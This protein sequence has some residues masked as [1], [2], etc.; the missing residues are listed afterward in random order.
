M[1]AIVHVNLKP[2]VL[3]PQGRAIARS[4]NHMGFDMVE[5][6]RQGK[7]LELDLK[8]DNPE[9][10]KAEVEKMCEQLLAN[11]VIENYEFEISE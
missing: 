3:D 6:V 10:A 7:T 11:T 8:S 4:L 1:K 5:D 9:D 2:G